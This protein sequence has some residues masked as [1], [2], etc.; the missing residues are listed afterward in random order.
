MTF[1]HASTPYVLLKNNCVNI[2]D[3]IHTYNIVIKQVTLKQNI[4]QNIF[5]KKYFLIRQMIKH[6]FKSY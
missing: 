2:K 5:L 6:L 3:T 1:K 4:K